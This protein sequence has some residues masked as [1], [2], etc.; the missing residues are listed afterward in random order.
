MIKSWKK[1][2][3]EGIVINIIKAIYD[4]SVAKIMVNGKLKPC[5][6]KS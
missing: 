6:I 1:L 4:K 5:P 3:T 2:R